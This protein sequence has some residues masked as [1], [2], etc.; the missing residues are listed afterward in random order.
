MN[1]L[2]RDC[3]GANVSAAERIVFVALDRDDL[4]AIMLNRQSTDGFAQIA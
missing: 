3:L 2:K 4:G 1:V